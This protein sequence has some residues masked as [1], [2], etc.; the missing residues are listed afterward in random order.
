MAELSNGSQDPSNESYNV[1]K[2]SGSYNAN[3]WDTA[4]ITSPHSQAS[5]VAAASPSAIIYGPHTKHRNSSSSH[6][7]VPVEIH[8]FGV[9]ATASHHRCSKLDRRTVTTAKEAEVFGF[10]VS[11]VGPWVGLQTPI[12]LVTRGLIVV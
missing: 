1:R 3:F 2:F 11:S 9:S 10:Y 7:V 6:C 12:V 8:V 4:V 5:H